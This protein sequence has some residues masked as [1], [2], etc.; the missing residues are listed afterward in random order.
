MNHFSGKVIKTVLI[1]TVLILGFNGCK[2]DYTSV[3]PAVYV[4]MDINPTNFIEFNIPGGSYYFPSAGFGGIIIFRDLVDSSNPYLAFDAACTYEVSSLVRVVA[5]ESGIATCPECK[6]QFIL[7]G[8]NGAP[9]KG[10]AAEPLKQYRTSF[11]AGRI[12]VRN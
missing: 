11:V 12:N 10:P 5:H 7:F 6:S 9:I 2:D 4:N 1:L 8:G 3:I